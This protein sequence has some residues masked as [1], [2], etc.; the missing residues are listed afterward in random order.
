MKN[1]I[2]ICEHSRNRFSIAQ[3]AL[4]EFRT[5]IDPG[6]FAALVRVR[7]NVVENANLPPF[8]YEQV[9]KMRPY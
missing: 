8:T 3:I 4:N 5:V 2:D 9:H 7:L 1:D 6:W